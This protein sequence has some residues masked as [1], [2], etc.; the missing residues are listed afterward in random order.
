MP[1]YEY[2]CRDCGFLTEIVAKINDK[3]KT[4]VCA[5]CG[6]S[7]SHAVVSKVSVR[8]SSASKV[9]RLDPKYDKMVDRAMSSNSASDPDTYLRRMGD[10]ARGRQDD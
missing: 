6:S 10:P 2:R 1:A 9:D 7:N 4:V 3:P 8:L 5:S